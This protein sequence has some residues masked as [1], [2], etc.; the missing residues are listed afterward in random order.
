MRP[1]TVLATVLTAGALLSG[2]QSDV[3]GMP[4]TPTSG[5]GEPSFPTSRPS[6][7][8]PTA[9]PPT[10]T[11]PSAPASPPAAEVLPPQDA[12]YVFIATK[13]GQVRCQLDKQS[14]ACEALF[15][16]S[17]IKDGVRANGVSLSADGSVAWIVGNL[18]DIPAV[19]IDYRMYSAV[20]WT[21][22][23]TTDGTRFTNQQTKHGMF[24]SIDKVETY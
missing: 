7:N 8:R 2:C 18:G 3:E 13:S 17:P 20:G 4:V 9:A 22:V 6:T 24:V 14:V 11:A 16:N 1:L 21:I 23:A 12:G 15:T 5:A 19:T 10:K